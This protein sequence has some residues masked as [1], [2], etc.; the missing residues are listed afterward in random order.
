MKKPILWLALLALLPATARADFLLNTTFPPGSLPPGTPLSMAAG[1]TSATMDLTAINT[2]ASSD[3]MSAW[4]VRL[5]IKPVGGATG[6]V[7]F[8]TLF[9]DPTDTTNLPNYVFGTHSFAGISTVLSGGNEK[10]LASDFLD[11]AFAL[12]VPVPGGAGASLLGLNFRATGNASGL[13]GIYAVRGIGGLTRPAN[14]LWNDANG[15]PRTFSNVPDDTSNPPGEVL[16]GGVSV[17]PSVTPVVPEPASWLLL[18]LGIGVVVVAG[19]LRA[20]RG[21]PSHFPAA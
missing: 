10:L 7:T 15:N 14:T 20:R 16:I 4:Q 5:E 12:G 2:N 19:W 8:Q 3:L 11:P 18:G 21:S 6:T 17:T 9:T 1:T 13:F